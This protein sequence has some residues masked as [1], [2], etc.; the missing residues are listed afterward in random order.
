[1]NKLLQRVNDLNELDKNLNE[2]EIKMNIMEK[3]LDYFK[4]VL[5]NPSTNHSL[6]SLLDRLDFVCFFG[7]SKKNLFRRKRL[8]TIRTDMNTAR[9]L[10]LTL[11]QNLE[12]GLINSEVRDLNRS[13]RFLIYSFFFFLGSTCG[14]TIENIL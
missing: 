7:F 3:R 11:Y 10:V 14:F 12:S 4:T 13:F 1:M 9:D 6:F 8:Q 2:Q 5:E